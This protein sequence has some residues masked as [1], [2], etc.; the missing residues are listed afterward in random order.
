MSII[1]AAPLNLNLPPPPILVHL[2]Y[3]ELSVNMVVFQA[4][5][6][7]SVH[8]TSSS[9]SATVL[10]HWRPVPYTFTATYTVVDLLL[11]L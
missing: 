3:R 4:H 5:Y 6:P 10:G 9:A 8:H 1:D 2:V 11:I 7:N